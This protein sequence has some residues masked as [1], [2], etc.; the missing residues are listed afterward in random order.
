M[1]R[2][3][4]AADLHLG[5][6][7][8]AFSAQRAA[9]ARVRRLDALERL[10]WAA[11]QR[12]AQMILLAGDVFDSPE[13]EPNT[14]N[15]FFALCAALPIPVVIAPG[16]HDPYRAGSVWKRY[17]LPDNVYVFD[18]EAVCCIDF[19]ALGAAVYGYA[20]CQERMEA[21]ALGTAA[22]LLPDR[23]SILLG[24]A[25]LLS[26]LSAYAPI[27]AGQLERTGYRYAALGH[28]HKK[29]P[30]TRYG[31]VTAA[32]AGFFAGSGFDELG[33]GRSLLVEIEGERV[34]VTPLESTAD[35]F[36]WVELDC[37]GAQNNEEIYTRLRAF[38]EKERFSA[39]TALRITLCGN[40]GL[41]CQV[42]P[43]RL[44]SLG[45]SFSIFEIRDVTLPIH[46]G[47]YLE[48]D[49]TLRGAFYRAMLPRLR[50][51]DAEERAVAAEA[52]Q[53]GLA[54]LAGREV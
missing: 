51:G 16:N 6:P 31:G 45:A 7:M 28:I 42:D 12:G 10:F 41:D 14:A 46:D 44:A 11:V 22:D 54:A 34:D 35:R 39:E 27:T 32:Y 30:P 4:H 5:S 33:T 38:L 50:S 20:F 18:S 40:V 21:P 17:A 43:L 36:E 19:P 9:A 25:D 49:P 47:V 48:K 29:A 52:L 15:R 53:L 13:P 3:L 24:H 1:L 2:F 8:A 23:V 37:G 26:P